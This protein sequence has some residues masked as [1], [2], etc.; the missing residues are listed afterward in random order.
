MTEPPLFL[1]PE[2][3][4]EIHHDQLQRYGGRSGVRD[5][6]L[7]LSAIAAPATGFGG[8]FLHED[9][10]AMAAAYLFHLAQNHPFLDGNKRVAVVAAATFLKLNGH[11]LTA[12]PDELYRITL[13]VA[14]G[15]T[16]KT[17]LAR[18]IRTNSRPA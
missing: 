8:K 7:M 3:V 14:D 18:F 13:A 12:D 5:L 15:R 1:T 17:S 4:L 11:E 2:E 16:D 10:A 9:L 6:G